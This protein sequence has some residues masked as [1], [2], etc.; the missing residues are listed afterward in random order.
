MAMLFEV[1]G[2]ILNASVLEGDL[3]LRASRV[4]FGSLMLRDDPGDFLLR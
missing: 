1:F 3:H 2:E 4:T